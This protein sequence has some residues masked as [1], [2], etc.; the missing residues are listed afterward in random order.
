MTPQM[1]CFYYL[2]KIK[3]IYQLLVAHSGSTSLS[4]RVLSKNGPNK[5]FGPPT[6]K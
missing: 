1:N 6:P 3:T 2:N 4:L 5:D